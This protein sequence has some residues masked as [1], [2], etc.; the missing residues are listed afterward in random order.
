LLRAQDKIKINLFFGQISLLNL[1]IHRNTALLRVPKKKQPFSLALITKLLSH[2]RRDIVRHRLRGEEG[3]GCRRRDA[4]GRAQQRVQGEER[5]ALGGSGAGDD[6]S[7][8][9]DETVKRV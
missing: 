5:P 2:F 1:K 6:D 9:K 3:D 4:A 8:L 7:R